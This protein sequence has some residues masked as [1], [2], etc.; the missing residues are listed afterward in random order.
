MDDSKKD[1]KEKEEELV[2]EEDG[3]EESSSSADSASVATS[4]K[5]TA[6]EDKEESE[7]EEEKAGDRSEGEKE[8]EE[9]GDQE[10][11]EEVDEEEEESKDQEPTHE[12]ISRSN[13]MRR[14]LNQFVR[15][16]QPSYNLTPQSKKLS[17][18]LLTLILFILAVVVIGGGIYFLTGVGSP[19]KEQQ[20]STVP[21]ST[22]QASPTPEVLNRS[23]WSFEVLNG[24]GVTGEAKRI[25]DALR[26]LGY[27]VIKVGNAD[28]SDYT[29][30]Q[31]FV[32]EDLQDE[33]DQI[34]VD[35]KDIIKIA[36]ISGELK[37]ATASARIIIGK[38]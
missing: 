8:E 37:D 10:K 27:Q 14:D 28:R 26:Q 20:P 19:K 22:P 13:T 12:D 7:V 31:F 15:D 34:V 1:K 5:E 18:K 33:V 4:A 2:W 36:S 23:E 29:S 25:A 38:E 24:S 3:K 21:T 30:N 11:E 17:G 16:N 35:I 32:R 9:A 6:S